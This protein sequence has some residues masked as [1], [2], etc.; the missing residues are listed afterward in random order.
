MMEIAEAFIM[1][2]EDEMVP[3][4]RFI[5]TCFCRGKGL[6]GSKYYTD[7]PSS[8]INTVANLNII[9]LVGLNLY[10]SRSRLYY[11]IGSDILSKIYMMF[12][13]SNQDCGADHR[14]SIQR[15]TTLYR[16]WEMAR[17][18]IL[19]QIWSLSFYQKQHTSYLLLQRDTQRLS[20]TNRYGGKNQLRFT[21]KTH[22]F[23]ISYSMGNCQ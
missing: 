15:P 19:F 9:W 23:D 4:V 13:K 6:L 22:A 1:A 21:W 5:F 16:V 17:K 12:Q 11:L 14:L 18:P 8:I 3:G 7:N 10:I 20:C 2:K